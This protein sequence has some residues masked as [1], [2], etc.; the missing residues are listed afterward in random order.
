MTKVCLEYASTGDAPKA[1]A[2]SNPD[3]APHLSF[4]DMGLEANCAP[5][6]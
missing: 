3:N 4:V 5:S 2:A 1:R 6:I